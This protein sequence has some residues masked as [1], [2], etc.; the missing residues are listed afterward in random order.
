MKNS[1]IL[2][3]LV[4]LYVLLSMV[5]PNGKSSE[6]EKKINHKSRYD[7]HN[8]MIFKG[9]YLPVMNVVKKD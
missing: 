3:G 7:I 1:S 5:L 8:K 9:D 4:I 6:T 2:F